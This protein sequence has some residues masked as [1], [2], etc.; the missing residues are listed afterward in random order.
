MQNSLVIVESP[1][2]IAS[3]KRYLGEGFTVKSSYGHVRD[4]P[5]STEFKWQM[6]DSDL[7]V[8][9]EDGWKAEYVVIPGK[10]KV[11]TELAAIANKVDVVYLATDLDREGESIAWHLQELIT[12]S[13]DDRR[14]DAGLEALEF[15][16]V[17]FSEITRSSIQDAFAEP[18]SVHQERVDA[19]QAR[20]FLDR[21]VGFRL[22]ELLRHKMGRGLSAGRVQSVAVR[23]IVE[24]EREVRSF[25]PEE[26]WEASAELARLGDEESHTFRVTKESDTEF[27]PRNSTEAHSALDR[28]KSREFRVVDV[29]KRP[30]TSRPS[31]PFITSTLQQAASTNLGFSGKK[32]MY[33]AQRLYEAGVITYMRTD[34]TNLSKEALQ[35]VRELIKNEYGDRYLPEKPNFYSS[36]AS[37]Q[38]AHEAIRPTDP[39]PMRPSQLLKAEADQRRLYDLI[40]NRFI[41]CQMTPAQFENTTISLEAGEFRLETKGKI[42][43]FDGHTRVPHALRKKP[44]DQLVPEYRPNEQ[45]ECREAKVEQHFT[46]PKP[47]YSEASLI[48]ELDKRGIGR[49]STFNSIIAKIEDR[50]YVTLKSKRFHAER[51]GELVTDRLGASFHKLMDYEFTEDVEKDLD[52]IAKGEVEWRRVLD[53]F[54][55]EFKEMLEKARGP[56][57]MRK[58]AAIEVDIQ[59]SSCGRPMNLRTAKTGVFLGCSGFN[60][61]KKLQCKETQNLIATEDLPETE[62]DELKLL[63]S[64]RRCKAC[65]WMMLS[66]L[67]DQNRIL[68]LC[69]NT[70]DC[71][72]TEI[73]EGQ[74]ELSKY[75]GPVIECD[76]CGAEMQKKT[77]RFG[78][79]F[80]C[81]ECK[82]TRKIK[83]NGEIAAPKAD[84]IPM[85]EL[86]CEGLDDYYVLRDGEAGIFLAASKYPKN[87]KTRSPRV[88]ELISHANE[89]D[90]KFKH[91][92]TAP[93]E[94]PDGHASIVRFSR[95]SRE[96]FVTVEG[97]SRNLWRCDYRQGEWHLSK[98]ASS[99]ASKSPNQAAS[100]KA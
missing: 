45:L 30:S 26:Y 56:E 51:M 55:T 92:L 61:P 1:G 86:R 25:T 100:N 3:I 6:T 60:Q 64:G 70:C 62:D 94:S 24:R 97:K 29:S 36:K 67:V 57:G 82:N 13:S 47:K 2:K 84:P 17:I 35:T 69:S 42:L 87:R 53:E 58:N 23:L 71:T 59:C 99:A 15:K 79:Y 72:A 75:A 38:E 78:E 81:T 65:G 50:G 49:P 12:E 90:P 9:P 98:G 43:L 96:H 76:K 74:F 19:Q 21:V 95:K 8:D 46:R 89:L 54:Y 4:L 31:A 32:T 91:L 83:A 63:L 11:I 39:N 93:T 88:S 68:H 5:A 10:E 73:E 7:G 22:S 48:K 44:G 28:L 41:A 33:L 34:S 52:L 66:Y 80:S 27:R 37:A 20:R 77:G 85:P 18:G 16:R 14:G 40:R